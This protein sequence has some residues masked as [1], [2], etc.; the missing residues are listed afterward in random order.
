MVRARITLDNPVFD[1][2]GENNVYLLESDETTLVDAGIATDRTRAALERELAAHG[3]DLADVDH[4]FLTHWHPDHAGLA[5]AVQAESGATIH[6]HEADAPLVAGVTEAFE[7]LRSSRLGAL[8]EW[9][10]PPDARAEIADRHG[11]D[12]GPRGTGDP[13]TVEPFVEGER[14]DLGGAELEAV[15]APGHTAGE[16]CF[17]LDG[18]RRA[19]FTGDALLPG[20]TANVGG[21]DP[22]T[23]GALS[24]HLE[25]L[26]A[27]AT[28]GFDRGWPG[29]GDPMA[30]PAARAR[31][32][33][34]HH[35]DRAAALLDGLAEPRT[36]WE[37]TQ[38]LFGDLAETHLVLG[39]GEAHAHLEHLRREGL[40]ERTD[41]R[42]VAVAAS[43]EALD[44]AFPEVEA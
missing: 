22:R 9:E 20:Y 43:S 25:T 35:R 19:V 12:P 36:V 26:A 18:E 6:V 5:G 38:S 40:V 30:D 21:A 44:C 37:A 16:T 27:L 33:L 11:D 41:G 42:Y 13:P 1:M 3:H 29:H 31:A 8:G 15:H 17:V 2:E 34:A 23:E 24:V 39:L 10:V 7:A 14:F 4:V 32:V 28:G